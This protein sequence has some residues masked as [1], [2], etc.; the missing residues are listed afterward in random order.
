MKEAAGRRSTTSPSASAVLGAFVQQEVA[1]RF[2]FT[3]SLTW[4][5]EGSH[6]TGSVVLSAA[7]PV[8]R[9]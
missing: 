2:G 5:F 7:P 6:L 3:F 9:T 1:L 8:G 4:G